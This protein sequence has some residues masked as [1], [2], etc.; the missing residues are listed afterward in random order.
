MFNSLFKNFN[1]KNVT[2]L[3]NELKAIYTYN[4]FT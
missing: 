1:Y 3:N 2:G 4:K